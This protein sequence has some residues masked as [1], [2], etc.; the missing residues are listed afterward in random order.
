MV[1]WRGILAGGASLSVL[2]IAQAGWTQEIRIPV[3]TLDSVTSTATKTEQVNVDVLGSATSLTKDNIETLNPK[4]LGDVFRTIPNVEIETGSRIGA[5]QLNI[6]G[7]SDDRIVLRLDGA[8]N[9]FNAGHRGRIFIDTDT[10]KQI[11]I[12]RGPSPIWGSGAIGGVVSLELKDHHDYLD[13]GKDMGIRQRIGFFGVNDAMMSST[14]VFAGFGDK[15]EFGVVGNFTRYI[16]ANSRTGDTPSA[17]DLDYVRYSKDNI[18]SGYAKVLWEPTPEHKFTFSTQIYD[19]KNF[20]PTAADA[21]ATTLIADRHTLQKNF[22]LQYNYKSSATPLIDL[23]VR[24]Y[25]T[26]VDIS[27]RV[28]DNNANF[29][30]YDVTRL[31]TPGL[32][33]YN[34]SRFS[35]LNGN[36]KSALTY[37]V[38]YYRDMQFGRRNEQPRLQH[39]DAQQDVAGLYVQNEFTLWEQVTVLGGLRWDYYSLNPSGTAN[40]SRD[41]DNLAKYGAIA[42]RPMP[43]LQIYGKYTE[44]FRVPG[45]T[46]LYASGQH[47]PYFGPFQNVFIPNPDLRPEKAKGWEVGAGL[48]FRDVIFKGDKLLGKFSWFRTTV[49]DYI[50]LELANPHP[51]FGFPLTTQAVNVANA[52]L[53]GFEVEASY[54]ARWFFLGISYGRTRGTNDDTGA[55]L[56]SIPADKL[57]VSG[58]VRIPMW[59]VMFGGRTIYVADQD[60]IPV[61]GLPAKSYVVHD[62]FVSWQPTIENFPNARWLAGFRVDAGIDNVTDKYYQPY[63]SGVPD[64]G[65][66]FKA[67]VSYTLQFS[68]R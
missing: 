19:D 42:W 62:V 4:S 9:N 17:A 34:T 22:A 25:Y 67:A 30:R 49:D 15:N 55:Y 18:K 33:I 8:R 65:R 27:E 64:P 32:D 48:K 50:D 2:A 47:F 24:G 20:I 61:D 35:F 51:V 1:R 41:D 45:L 37:G 5:Q 46:E 13:P 7:F 44:S 26:V 56:T 3:T 23:K 38:E 16:S 68:T 66:N 12:V 14:T 39:P 57:V 43:W 53:T 31:S 58:G 40:A 54:Q 11:D 21:D 28:I 6:R 52:L 29:G 10:L 60:R 36:V 63:L 59:D